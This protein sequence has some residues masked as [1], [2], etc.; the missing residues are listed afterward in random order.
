M[1]LM[2]PVTKQY[3]Y[4]ALAHA[5][6]VWWSIEKSEPWVAK[7]YSSCA[8][9]HKNAVSSR[10]WDSASSVLDD[11]L[12]KNTADIIGSCMDRLEHVERALVTYGLC[13]QHSSWVSDMDPLRAQTRYEGAL[14]SLAMAARREGVD[15]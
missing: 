5:V 9:G 8:P 4:E 6:S 12:E 15:V 10:Q 7:G 13:G 14:L 2:P 11:E 1:E 3:N